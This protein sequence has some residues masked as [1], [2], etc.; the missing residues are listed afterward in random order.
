[1]RRLAASCEY[2]EI[3]FDRNAVLERL[4]ENE[5][6]LGPGTRYKVRLELSTDGRMDVENIVIEEEPACSVIVFAPQRTSS[7][8]IFVYHKTTRRDLYNRVHA[9]ARQR[10]YADAVFENERGEITEGAI[11]NI[12][13]E[14]DGALLTPPVRCGLLPGVYREHVLATNPR[15]RECVLRREDLQRAD[16]IYMCNAVLGLRVVTLAADRF[17]PAPLDSPLP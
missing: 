10:G 16:T 6:R 3:V 8:D 2:F 5:T 1:M 15:A 9:E 11:S 7:R 12:F 14:K 17:S 4:G 13:I